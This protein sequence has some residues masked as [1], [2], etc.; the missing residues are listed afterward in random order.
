ML[1]QL[2]APEKTSQIIDAALEDMGWAELPS[3]RTKFEMLVSRAVA[4]RVTALLGS[5]DAELLIEELLRIAQLMPDDKPR[6]GERPRGSASITLPA[7]ADLVIALATAS[8]ARLERLE[9]RVVGTARVRSVRDA[10]SLFDVLQSEPVALLVVDLVDPA[11]RWPTLLALAEDVPPT[12]K[13][14]VFCTDAS[15]RPSVREHGWSFVADETE[16]D[17]AVDSLCV[18]E[19]SLSE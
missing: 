9:G 14:C 7:P 3:S 17:A 4:P 5:A 13:V 2:L 8:E 18:S 10:I 16:L 12:A 6:S 1:G 19:E 15:L 11:L